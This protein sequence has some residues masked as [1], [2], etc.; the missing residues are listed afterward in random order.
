MP[1]QGVAVIQATICLSTYLFV[2]CVQTL[3]FCWLCGDLW[4]LWEGGLAGDGPTDGPGR[5]SVALSATGLSGPL[6]AQYR[7]LL[8]SV[9]VIPVGVGALQVGVH[10]QACTGVRFITLD[11]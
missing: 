8:R 10:V 5:A 6:R 11:G 9:L 4:G 3:P 7:S 1:A 2:G